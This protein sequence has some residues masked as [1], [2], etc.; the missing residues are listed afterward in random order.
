[1]EENNYRYGFKIL[2]TWNIENPN[3][4]K[5]TITQVMKLP[6]D[7]NDHE[8]RDHNEVSSSIETLRTFAT[9]D[10]AEQVRAAD[11][12]AQNDRSGT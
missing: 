9:R 4:R 12:F 2:E 10:A 1:M 11:L 8:T 6:P 7:V 5:V 3:D